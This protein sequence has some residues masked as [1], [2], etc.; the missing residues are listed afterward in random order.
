MS[1][2]VSVRVWPEPKPMKSSVSTYDWAHMPGPSAV[3]PVIT[4]FG[5]LLPVHWAADVHLGLSLPRLVS[6]SY[7]SAC[8]AAR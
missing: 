8:P 2:L 1:L 3:S 7:E 4:Q 6:G 5:A